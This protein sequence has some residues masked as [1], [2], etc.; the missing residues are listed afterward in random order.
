MSKN[1]SVNLGDHFSSY[2]GIQVKQGRYGSAS[3]VIR[4]ALR[5]LENQDAKLNA[6]RNKLEASENQAEKGEF[7]DYS[8]EKLT[9][10]LD[11]ENI[12]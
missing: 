11:Q 5:L 8:L 10:E 7:A 12:S 2:V 4:A 1:T 9:N 6:L 3:E